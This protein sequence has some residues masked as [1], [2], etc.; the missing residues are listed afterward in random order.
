MWV[1]GWLCIVGFIDVFIVFLMF[2]DGRLFL[3]EVI[4][5]VGV[6]LMSVLIGLNG[7]GKIIFLCIICGD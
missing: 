1:E 3:D 2:F 4:F 5:W 6:G 7:V